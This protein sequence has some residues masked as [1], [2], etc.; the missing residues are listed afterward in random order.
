MYANYRK[1]ELINSVI[2]QGIAVT[3]HNQIVP[4]STVVKAA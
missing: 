1:T 3:A 4:G 2:Y